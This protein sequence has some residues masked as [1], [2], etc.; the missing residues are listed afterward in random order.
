MPYLNVNLKSNPDG[1][2]LAN[3]N[4]YDNIFILDDHKIELYLYK[5][6]M[7]DYIKINYTHIIE[8]IF[9]KNYM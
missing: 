3:K 6:N 4:K 7:K 5:S 8:I 1:N 9:L 2:I